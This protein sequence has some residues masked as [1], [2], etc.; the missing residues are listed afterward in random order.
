MSSTYLI[1]CLSHDPATAEG[2]CRTPEEA[3]ERIRVGVEGHPSCDL[4]LARRSGGLIE[5]GCPDST[6]PRPGQRPCRMHGRT[7][8]VDVAWLRLLAAAHQSDNEAQRSFAEARDF[9]CWSW[10]R[11]RRLRDWL[12]IPVTGQPSETPS[13]DV[14]TEEMPRS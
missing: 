3:A 7:E 10:E 5:V 14:Y 8:W 9:Q 1:L 13:R 2:E 4:L 6:D 11:L 12:D